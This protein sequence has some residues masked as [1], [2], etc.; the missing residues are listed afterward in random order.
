MI[1]YIN[2]CVRKESR[3][4]ILA[5]HLLDKLDGE[6]E[7]V[8]LEDIDF[9]KVNE[10]YLN[11]RDEL[12]NR[13]AYDHPM[14][15]LANQF[16]KADIIVIAAPYWDLSFPASLKQYL[17][18]INVSGL[19]FKYS[20]EGYP[21]GLCQAKKLYYVMTAGGNYLPEEYG[22]GYVKDMAE[23]FYGIKDFRLIKVTGLDIIGND[24]ESLLKKGLEEIDNL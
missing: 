24:A 18:V 23:S 20:D 19:T 3:T 13:E 16:K 1:L 8:R 2:A 22:Y 11:I 14:F 4:R 12:I 9:P 15:K 10:T 6:V 21:I 17:E 7:E 5:E